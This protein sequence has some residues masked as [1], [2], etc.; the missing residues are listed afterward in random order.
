MN[1]KKRK[2]FRIISIVLLTLICIST[3]LVGCGKKNETKEKD[4]HLTVYLWETNL[5]KEIVPYIKEQFPD[6]EIEFIVGNNNVDLY[7]YLQEH[8]DLPDIITTRRFSSIDAG[9]LQPYLLDFSAY[10]IVSQY[11]PYTVQYYSNTDGDIQWL[12]VCGIPETMIVNK[13]MLEQY[14]IEIPKNYQ[15]FAAACRKLKEN[16]I[17]PYVSELKMDW[18]AHSILQGAAINQFSSL[19]GI[20]WRS[21]AESIANGNIPFDDEMWTQVF[22]E[23]HS[24]IK[25]TYLT[26]E[27]L[28]R[29]LPVVKGEFINR[30]A[31]MFRGTPAVMSELEAKMDDELVRIPYFSQDSN[32]SWIYTYPSFNV[33]LNK[34]LEG[35]EQKLKDAMEVLDCFIS[36]KGQKIIANG[37]GMISYNAN[38]ESDLS[39]MVGVEEEIGKNAFYIR[40]A[41]NHSFSASLKSIQGMVS[42]KMDET[43]AYETFKKELNSKKKK[44]KSIID[45][46]NQYNLSIN[47]KG[48]RDA[49]SSVLNTVRKEMGADLALSPYYYYASSIYKGKCTKTQA[50][51]MIAHNE[52][53]LLYL[54]SLS[55]KKIKEIINDYLKGEK[56]E[57]KITN[58]YELPIL[59]GMKFVVKKEKNGFTVENVVLNGKPI[60]EKKE[61]KILL[62]GEEF[63]KL[64]TSDE[65]RPLDLLLDQK[66]L[67]IIKEGKQPE[68]PEDYILVKE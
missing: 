32:E 20:D 41:S 52:D 42:G 67:D 13:T 60:D 18:A 66:W 11:Y 57:F 30:K 5:L 3:L 29:S 1:K 24:F 31:A 51:M 62:V 7:N 43:Q 2:Y 16:G 48:G 44:E 47:E 4:S 9:E 45:F 10:D 35:N 40:Y 6:K 27:D 14:G 59:S 28:Y 21:K 64:P 58:Q 55:G 22:S 15:Q 33:A 26:K 19:K 34:K 17:K 39:G 38:V 56:T 61:Y 37:S 68:K 12:P 46:E 25:D 36:E 49:A 53:V 8:G 50:N 23:V 65:I 54:E 63:S